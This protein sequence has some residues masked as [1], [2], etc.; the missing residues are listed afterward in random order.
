MYEQ[1]LEQ[2]LEQFADRGLCAAWPSRED[3]LRRVEAS[4]E[5]PELKRIAMAEGAAKYVGREAL[6]ERLG[7]LARRWPELRERLRRQLLPSRR[8]FAMF[9]QG[10][11]PATGAAI[12]I[13]PERLRR[14]CF[15][16]QQIRRRYTV[17]DLALETGLLR[18][19]VD[20][21]FDSAGMRGLDGPS[22]NAARS[23]RRPPEI[24]AHD[25]S[26]SRPAWARPGRPAD[27]RPARS[28]ARV[29]LLAAPHPVFDDDRIRG[30]LL[31]AEEP[32]GGHARHG[33]GS[34]NHQRG[35]RVV[36]D[37]QRPGL[38]RVEIRQRVSGRP[39]QSP[40]LH[41]AGARLRGRGE[42]WIRI[43]DAVATLGVFWLL[44]GWFQGMGF[45]PCARSLSNWFAPGE[46]GTKFAIWNTSHP[47]GSATV[48]VLCG[49]LVAGQWR[50]WLPA[51][52]DAWLP[53]NWRLCFFLPA[54]I[55]L[56]GA[57]FLVHRL[58]DRP[59]SLGLPPVTER[60]KTASP[61]RGSADIVE[62]EEMPFRRFVLYNVFLNPM[63][64]VASLANFFVYTVRYTVLDW[65]PTFLHE[66]KGLEIQHTG[67]MVAAYEL[68]GL[69][70]ILVSGWLMDKAKG[71]G[72]RVCCVSMF[73]CGLCVLAFWKLRS[74][75]IV[76][77]TLLLCGTGFFIYGPQCLVGVL[78]ANLASR[79]AA[80]TAI[81]MTG[82]FGYLSTALS[83][84]GLGLLVER[85]KSWDMAFQ[86][87]IGAAAVATVLFGL[88]YNAG[89]HPEEAGGKVVVKGSGVFI[90]TE[91]A[92]VV[93]FGTCHDDCEFPPADMPTTC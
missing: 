48:L 30:L 83:G 56:A 50:A 73:L 67:W 88:M 74:D 2:D 5:T 31:R 36:P 68:T 44:N 26:T 85:T 60:A 19:S 28:V 66:M 14:S 76:V 37:A 12:G 53:A 46:R 27:P 79:R 72:G 54:G 13:V 57:V 93:V 52:V 9:E 55:A 41:A 84:W 61:E 29:S 22:W 20:A 24:A 77:N 16:A 11:L 62:A 25:G 51:S 43:V 65:G 91:A 92:E 49:Y 17:L 64:W 4:H 34:G 39:D 42:H 71:K 33:G 35:S 3:R 63:V 75:S 38:R 87:L 45:P 23:A 90:L 32:L 58:R 47:V 18:S 70:G 10:G 81:G 82:F 69:T 89:Y 59:E 7:L 15:E 86:I 80:A 40:V 21:V 1:L 8:L 78:A 6:A